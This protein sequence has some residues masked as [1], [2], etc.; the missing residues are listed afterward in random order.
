MVGAPPRTPQGERTALPEPLAGGEGLLPLPKNPSPALGLQPFGLP[1]SEGHTLALTRVT[2]LPTCY[3]SQGLSPGFLGCKTTS[4]T[5]PIELLY[6]ILHSCTLFYGRN[7]VIFSIIGYGG[8]LEYSMMVM[9]SLCRW[10]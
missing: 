10:L 2:G 6:D 1:P 4:E 3:Q 5:T 9:G 7:R 8:T